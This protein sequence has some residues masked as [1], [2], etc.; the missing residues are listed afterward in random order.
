MKNIKL[1]SI[2]LTLIVFSS[3]LVGCSDGKTSTMSQKQT[4]SSNKVMNKGEI[5]PDFQL[6][7]SKG[8]IHKLSD[9]KGKKVYIKFWASWCSICLAGMDEVDTLASDNN[10]F[11]VLSVVSPSF[12]GEQ[13]KDDFMKWFN[14][15]GK[16]NLP[17]LLDTGGAL[18]NKLGVRGYPTSVFI[19]SD[20]VLV[21][22][23]PGH[24]SNEAIK[25]AYS[26]IL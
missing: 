20:G 23:L 26:T 2:F 6:T 18:A 7:D 21:K 17:V 4:S 13:N 24:K 14:S 1:F 3:T 15:L 12:R 5:A 16:K 10:D 22:T 8:N 11:V 25:E 9:Y 19:G